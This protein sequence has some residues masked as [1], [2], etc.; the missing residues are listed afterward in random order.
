MQDNARKITYGAMMIAVFA[1]LLA[2]SLYIPLVGSITMF[3]IPLPIILY[4]LKYDRASSLLVWVSGIVLSLLIGGV[5][6]APFAFVHG[7]L[8]LV[9]G[10]SV[11]MG[12]TKLYS[13]MATGL[14][15]LIS[16]MMIYVGA[17]LFLGFNAIDVL[18]T[19]IQES[20]E[21]T[22]SIMSKY[23]SLPDNYDETFDLALGMYEY[24]IPSLMILFVF[25]LAFIILTLNLGVAKRL[26]FDVPKFPPFREFK[27]PIIT[28][29][30]YGVILLI[31]FFTDMKPGTNLHLIITNATVILRFLFLLQGISLIHYYV[32]EKKLPKVATVAATIF[33]LMLTPITTMLGILDTGVNIRAWLSKDKLK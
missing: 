2:V 13:F 25:T 33:A 8:G 20:K 10:E 1:V 23:G 22:S 18:R 26:G 14:T 6:L 5:L 16:G 29:I 3:F 24:T 7:F 28:V 15:L 32:N 12:K 19:A 4:R 11:R 21:Q 31:T 30:L 9:I 27:L 17:V